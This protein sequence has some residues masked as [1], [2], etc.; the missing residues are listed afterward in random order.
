[1]S[2]VASLISVLATVGTGLVI[3]VWGRSAAVM[4]GLI[5]NLFIIFGLLLARKQTAHWE[6]TRASTAN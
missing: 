1:M 3:E 6:Q 2:A 4:T 5:L